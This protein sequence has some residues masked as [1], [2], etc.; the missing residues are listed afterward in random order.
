MVMNKNHLGRRHGNRPSDFAVVCNK[1]S[2][3]VEK[4]FQTETARRR[5]IRLFLKKAAESALAHRDAERIAEL[6]VEKCTHDI[7]FARTLICIIHELGRGNI[8]ERRYRLFVHIANNSTKGDRR[9][10]GR[11]ISLATLTAFLRKAPSY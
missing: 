9:V 11:I 4:E 7:Y 10:F 1:V 2:T 8:Y 5:A 6:L 3:L